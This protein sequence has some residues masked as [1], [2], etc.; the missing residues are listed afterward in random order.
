[1]Q[2]T[3]TTKAF[4][5]LDG[6]YR[7]GNGIEPNQ[8]VQF[9][10]DGSDNVLIEAFRQLDV[11]ATDPGGGGTPTIT[12]TSLA[13]GT[14]GTAYS[15]TLGVSGTGSVTWTLDNG[16]LPDGLALNPNTGE[17]SGI[18]TTA[19]TFNFTVKVANTAGNDTKPLS[20]I[21]AS[22]G[23]NPGDNNNGSGGGGCNAGFGLF[24]LLP[25]ALWFARKRMAA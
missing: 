7:E 6:V 21:I 25:L 9:I 2:V 24:G 8:Y 20:I 5:D 22:G 23:G 3:P 19:G 1:V 14:V 18:P 12:T 11:T 15:Q 17:I 13:G 10:N 16:N 4:K